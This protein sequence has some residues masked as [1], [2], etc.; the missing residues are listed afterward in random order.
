MRWF[1]AVAVFLPF[2]LYGAHPLITDDTGTQGGGRYQLEFV[3]ERASDDTA[4]GRERRTATNLTL[5]Y[6]VRET[7]DLVLDLPW[8]STRAEGVPRVRGIG[9]A[10]ATLKWRF[11]E[12]DQ[13]SLALKPGVS[14]AT[15]DE[16]KGLGAG[17]SGYSG[18]LVAS[19][20]SDPWALH[21]QLGAVR[22]RNVLHERERIYRASVGGWYTVGDVRLVIDVGRST[23]ADQADNRSAEFGVVGFI[24]GATPA[25]D[26]SVGYKKGLSFSET[27]RAVVAGVTYRF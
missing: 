5:S 18:F 27:D 21:G 3:G 13:V 25:L 17:R 9:D 6:G 24:Y 19:Y 20:V 12:R 26:L 14:F 2:S 11:F 1:L 8:Q 22:N 7:V 23:N 15:G 10:S 4:V 16:Y